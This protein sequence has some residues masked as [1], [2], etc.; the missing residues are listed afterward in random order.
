MDDDVAESL[1]RLSLATHSHRQIDTVY[2]S[3]AKLYR[4][5]AYD[6]K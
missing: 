4:Y 3:R 5:Q 6:G 1:G 2:V